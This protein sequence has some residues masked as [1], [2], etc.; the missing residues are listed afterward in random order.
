MRGHASAPS[1]K[2]RIQAGKEVKSESYA[3]EVSGV[4]AG[5]AVVNRGVELARASNCMPSWAS[6]RAILR[7][8]LG[9]S[10]CIFVN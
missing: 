1:R 2:R 7:S 5:A 10:L 4:V 8:S 6:S 3:T 9:R